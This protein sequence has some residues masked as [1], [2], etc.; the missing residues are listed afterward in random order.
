MGMS[1]ERRIRTPALAVFVLADT[2]KQLV[3]IAREYVN[4]K[5][6]LEEIDK[7]EETVKEAIQYL[8]ERLDFKTQSGYQRRSYGYSGGYSGYGRG[9]GS[10]RRSGSWR[11]RY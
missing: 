10:W 4:D 5:D 6:V 8:I 11:R 3:E 7:L 1:E 9:G 2:V